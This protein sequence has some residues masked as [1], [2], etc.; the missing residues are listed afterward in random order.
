MENVTFPQIEQGRLQVLNSLLA[1]HITLEQAAALMGV[2]PR[3]T[4]RI[5]AAYRGKGAAAVAHGHRVRKPVNATPDAVAEDVVLLVRTR[6]AGNNHSHLSE[7]LKQ[8]EGVDIGGTTLRRILVN[9]G[10]RST[11]TP[12][13]VHRG[14]PEWDPATPSS[15]TMAA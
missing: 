8:R 12:R 9:A 5:L 13:A 7:L 14:N 3:Y 15:G 11:W 4:R 2:S 6:Y 1:E 10:Q